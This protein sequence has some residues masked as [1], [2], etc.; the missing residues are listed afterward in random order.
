MIWFTADQHFFHENIIDY[1]SRP[2][3]R[4]GKMN[5]E[6]I[7][8]YRSVV[9]DADVVYMVGD[10]TIMGPQHRH[11]VEHI[12]SQ[13]P[14]AKILILGNHDKFDPFTYIDMGFQSVHTS[15]VVEEFTLV[16]DPAWSVVDSSRKWICGHI[17]TL[18]KRQ[19]NV[20]NVGVDQHE[21]YPIGIEEIHREFYEIL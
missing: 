8:R 18:F 17:H 15:L 19:G 11:A 7:R 12:I 13:L 14:G 1:C 10:F 3:P 5:N 20:L 6:I 16:H 21:F 2:F 9:G 4:V